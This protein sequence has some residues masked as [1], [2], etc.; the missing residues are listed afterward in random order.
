MSPDDEFETADTESVRREVERDERTGRSAAA[1][2]IHHQSSWVDQQIRIAMERGDFD[3]LAGYGKPIEDLGVEHD[4]DWWI[5][6][7]VERENIAILPPALALRKE[8]AELDGLLDR[9]NVESEVRR[10]VEDFN[11]RVRK[12][13][14]TPPTG[15]SGPP[16]ITR[17]RDVDDEVV[18]WRARRAARIEAQRAAREQAA[19]AEPPKR[20]WWRRH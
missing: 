8:D 19:A 12:A 6:K 10:E 20:R 14:Y 3:D 18:A 15:P 17:Q 16:V 13:I 2:R 11:A 1:A 7:L 4:P 5:K 9:I